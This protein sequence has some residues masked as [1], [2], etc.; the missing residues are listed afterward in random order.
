MCPETALNPN[1]LFRPRATHNITHLSYRHRVGMLAQSGVVKS[2]SSRLP[3][4]TAPG[5]QQVI[6]Y[7]LHK[8]YLTPSP[9]P[10]C[11]SATTS[12]IA[13]SP[14]GS[15]R[16]RQAS[17]A[18]G[19]KPG[20]GSRAAPAGLLSSFNRSSAVAYILGTLAK[21]AAGT[22]DFGEAYIA[23]K[24]NCSMLARCESE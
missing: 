20:P 4:C 15:H 19:E 23:A 8:A 18:S 7:P 24:A 12:P 10:P 17:R 22:E 13:I 14:D 1:K 9:Y 5:S 21:Q 16:G 6:P 2:R 11:S 3:A